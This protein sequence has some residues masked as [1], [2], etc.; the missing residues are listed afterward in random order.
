M[1][2]IFYRCGYPQYDA[3]HVL[4]RMECVQ[5]SEDEN[6]KRTTKGSSEWRTKEQIVSDMQS[7]IVYKRKDWSYDEFVYYP[8]RTFNVDG[9]DYIRTDQ[10]D[11]P[12]D[13]VP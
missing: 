6:G 3:D 2:E 4:T 5:V 7:G 12:K 13:N 9:V 8:L 11:I 10:R 1:G